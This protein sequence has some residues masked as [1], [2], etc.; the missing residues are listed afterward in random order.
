MPSL[1]VLQLSDSFSAL[2]PTLARECQL[3]LEV[4]TSVERFDTARDAVGIVA[5]GGEEFRLDQ[6]FRD[7]PVGDVQVAAVG[8]DGDRRVAIATMRAGAADFFALTDDLDLLRSWLHDQCE[9]LHTRHRRS[10]FAESQRTKYRFDGILGESQSLV[11]ALDRAA[12]IIPHPNVTV[13]ITGETG[14]G[15]E[16]LGRA[17]HYNGPRREAPFVDINCAAIPEQLLES[18]LFGHEKGA[19]T[20]ARNAKP[21]LFELA[22]GGTLFLDEIG[23]LP[24]TLQGKLL[25]VLQERQ[26][27]RV[28]ATKSIH[29]D[30][31][32]IAATHVNLSAAVKR[33]EFREDL[34]Y[35]L[36]VVPIELPPLRARV[37]DIVPLARHFLR[38]IAAEYNVPAP[39]LTTAAERVLRQRRWPGNVRELRN[40]IER[41]VLLCDGRQLTPMDVDVEPVAEPASENGIP[42]PAQLNT[43][44][45]AAVREM[46]EL[47]GGNKSEA[48]RRLGI[49]RTRFQRLLD[50]GDTELASEDET[51]RGDRDDAPIKLAERRGPAARIG[52]GR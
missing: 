39:Q 33:G 11:A 47:C 2:W 3:E 32:V 26:I 42:F 51:E 30:V 43:V 18:E 6:V 29:I 5:A 49:S 14:T 48:A 9:R 37:E 36:N 23:H 15:K 16:L 20:D 1:L 41:A 40:C 52:A 8:A 22:S 44:I 4:T 21:G 34:F 17:L 31:K 10:E 27:R 28:G 24:A 45:V 25:R 35:R 19:F 50:H 46:L 13:L 38:A 7:L 12:R